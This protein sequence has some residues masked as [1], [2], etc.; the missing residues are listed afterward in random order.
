MSESMP[1]TAPPRP[2]LS[3]FTLWQLLALVTFTGFGVGAHVWFELHGLLISGT[4]LWF[5][6][7]YY[8]WLKP[9]WV[10]A[11]FLLLLFLNFAIPGFFEW[12]EYNVR[13]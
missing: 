4:A 8:C 9:G 3:Q 6:A 1:A 10:E 11:V 5:V 7:S 2:A 13:Y 12:S